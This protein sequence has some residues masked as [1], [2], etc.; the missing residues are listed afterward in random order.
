VLSLPI[1]DRAALLVDSEKIAPLYYLQVTEHLRPDLDI[2]V[3]GD[4]TLYRQE[5]DRRI[6]SGQPVYLARFLPNLPYRL[7]SLGPLVEVSPQPMT[8]TP[9]LARSVGAMFGAD[10]NLLGVK[11]EPG[12]PYRLTLYWQAISPQRKNYHVRLRLVDAQRTVWWEDRGAHPVSGY[13][14]TGAWAQGEIVPDFHEINVEPY[15]PAGEYTLEVGLFTPFRED[16]LPV[17]GGSM[18]RDVATVRV[19]PH[20]AEALAHDERVIAGSIAI[21]SIDAL[22][23]VP[24]ASEVV[25][26]VDAIG[27]DVPLNVG[28][29]IGEL[30][31]S[32]SLQVGQSRWI[33]RAPDANGA[34]PLRL[35]FDSP[36]RCRW[37]A[38]LTTECEIGSMKVTGEATGAAID[39]DSQVLLTN[40]RIDRDTLRPNETIRVDLTW[41]GLKKWDGDY[42]VFVHLIGPD[43]KVHGQADQWPVQGTLPTSSW[44]TG[45]IVSDPYAITL[46]PDAP[47]GKYQIEV[48]WYLLATLRRLPVLDAAGRPS[49]DKVIVGELVVP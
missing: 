41:R 31:T 23:E 1:P 7:Q 45:Q 14:P 13:Y 28:V 21:T 43:G 25:L 36:T 49:D 16:G 22:G 11:D 42:T 5:L 39:F 30:T 6:A 19:A 40:A 26:R 46:P 44:N 27:G 37:L 2:L 10:I 38:P 9:S 33:L 47:S 8:T 24:P 12:D 34:Y 18:W 35:R 17:D 29:S 15:V 32:Q 20:A 4:E 48:G 3:L